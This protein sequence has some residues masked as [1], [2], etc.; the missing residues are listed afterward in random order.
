[1]TLTKDFDFYTATLSK[2]STTTPSQLHN[3]CCADA[4]VCEK[5]ES[6]IPPPHL[7]CYFRQNYYFKPRCAFII[8]NPLTYLPCQ[9]ISQ[10]LTAITVTWLPNGQPDIVEYEIPLFALTKRS[11]YSQSLDNSFPR[12]KK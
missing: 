3:A 4:N 8:D 2:I 10:M 5:S 6:C 9:G 11:L 7:Y 1:M 12:V